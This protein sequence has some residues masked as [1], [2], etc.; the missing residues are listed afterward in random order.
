MDDARL[1]LC[2]RCQRQVRICSYCDRGN[3]YCGRVCAGIARNESLRAAGRRYQQSR[4]GRFCHAARQRRY[5]A[6][7]RARNNK[8]THHGSVVAEQ[9][10]SLVRELHESTMSARRVPSSTPVCHFC[11]RSVSAL[12]RLGW[13]RR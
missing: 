3:Q 7:C 11:G 2:A 9:R 6:R 13:R 4:H 5:R 10:A 12:V 1:F 8:V